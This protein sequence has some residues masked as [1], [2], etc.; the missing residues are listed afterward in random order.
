MSYGSSPN[1]A[2]DEPHKDDP[3]HE[4]KEK[5]IAGKI[6]EEATDLAEMHKAKIYDFKS[7]QMIADHG[8]PK[9]SKPPPVY[10]KTREEKVSNLK[11]E[12][13]AGTYK[14]NAQHIASNIVTQGNHSSIKNLPKLKP[15]HAAKLIVPK[16]NKADE[17]HADDPKHEQ[18]EQDKAKKIKDKA[19]E[20]LDMHKGCS[21][22]KNGQ[23]SL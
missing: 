3:N 18:K 4:A 20:I 15:E 21:F 11:E 7:K 23:W 19:E 9:G 5:K 10:P 6:K 1:M 12:V 14:P 13:S 22:A 2:K 16:V 8:Q 17:C